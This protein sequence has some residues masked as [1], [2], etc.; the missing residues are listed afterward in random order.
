MA[1]PPPLLNLGP[2]FVCLDESG[3]LILLF[4]LLS[5]I[6]RSIMTGIYLGLYSTDWSDILLYHVIS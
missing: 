2:V 1:I 5:Q 4:V 3:P 6:I